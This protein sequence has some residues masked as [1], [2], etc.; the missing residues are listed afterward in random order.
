[1]PSEKTFV[2]PWGGTRSV[3]PDPPPA[4]STSSPFGWDKK[5]I[6]P[7]ALIIKSQCWQALSH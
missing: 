6:C 7:D 2:L 4:C 5:V 1:M 3:G